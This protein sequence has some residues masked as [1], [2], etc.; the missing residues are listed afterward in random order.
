MLPLRIAARFLLCGSVVR[1][2]NAQ[3]QV[4]LIFSRLQYIAYE[5]LLATVTITNRA[6]R[7]IDLNTD[8]GER[9]FG[10]E[11]T[12]S[13]GQSIPADSSLKM[14]PLRIAAAQT[15]TKK[16]N[17]ATY[18]PLQDLRTYHVQAQL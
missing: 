1:A 6:G 2:A 11:I 4:Q 9:W 10:F 13:D 14:E 8:A 15:V 17:L 7:D 18:Y 3:I 5:P 12:G 16:I